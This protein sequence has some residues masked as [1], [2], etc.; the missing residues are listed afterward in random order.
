M[1]T[2]SKQAV[3]ENVFILFYVIRWLFMILVSPSCLCRVPAETRWPLWPPWNELRECHRRRD[4]YVRN[5]PPEPRRS[6][7]GQ[8]IEAKEVRRAKIENRAKLYI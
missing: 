8:E 4:P 2:R 6:P 7:A 1:K 3:I 5:L